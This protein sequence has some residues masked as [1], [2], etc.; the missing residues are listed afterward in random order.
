MSKL[1]LNNLLILHIHKEEIGALNLPEVG[2]MFAAAKEI[3]G[4]CW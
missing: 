1:R 4:I 2:D 3:S